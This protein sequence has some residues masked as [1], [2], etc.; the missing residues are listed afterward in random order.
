M[1]ASAGESGTVGQKVELAHEV[2]I[3]V[4][5]AASSRPANEGR[6]D[7]ASLPFAFAPARLC[8][9]RAWTHF[10]RGQ[11]VPLA[12]AAVNDGEHMRE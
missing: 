11:W 1:K 8:P 3:W 9:V 6:A 10:I 4:V 2:G 12:T 7:L 5:L